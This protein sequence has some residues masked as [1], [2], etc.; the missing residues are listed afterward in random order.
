MPMD[1]RDTDSR[2]EITAN[3]DATLAREPELASRA[4]A[5][6]QQCIDKAEEQ[7]QKVTATGA[8][9]KDQ[10]SIMRDGLSVQVKAEIAKI[11]EPLH[12]ADVA[13]ILEALPND[14]RMIV[15]ELVQANQDG[16]VLVEVNEGVRET[17]IDAMDRDELVDAMETLDT[18]E[19]ADLVEDLPPDVV[20]EV[21]EGLTTKERAQ[22]RAAM[23]YPE[24]S[25]GA[26]MD[27]EIVSVREE[28]N[29]DTVLRYLR[30]FQEL[31]ELTDMIFVIDR[32]QKL[33]GALPV[34]KIIVSDPERTV[35]ELMQTDVL[36]LNPLDDATDAAQAFERYDL[37]SAPV[38]VSYTHLTLPTT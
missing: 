3:A 19:I 12:P 2:L 26:R 25:V 1:M 22:L 34:S 28:A 23:S 20:A 38:A 5:R 27:F 37:V 17:L 10:E 6:I 16:E 36:T 29:L 30:S 18:D 21:Q 13:Y 15:W 11:L 24:E 8:L 31:P 7:H 9:S 4:L 14:E 32:H 35:V 33:K